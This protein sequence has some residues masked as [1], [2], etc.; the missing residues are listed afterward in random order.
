M[1]RNSAL[2]RRRAADLLGRIGDRSAI[3]M[4]RQALP[5][6]RDDE[7]FKLAVARSLCAIGSKD[8][9]GPL[10]E[11]LESPNRATR[12]R[13][14][15]VLQRYT[16]LDFGFEHDGSADERAGAV[17]RWRQWWEGHHESFRPI[18]PAPP[19]P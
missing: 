10:I 11:L 19:P 4:L 2:R 8:G 16:H 7:A 1:F 5:N 6:A 18:A 15:V 12:V 14:Q 17:R 9:I 13:A 3:D